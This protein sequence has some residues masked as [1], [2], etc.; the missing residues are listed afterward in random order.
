MW[1]YEENESYSN[2]IAGIGKDSV[3]GLVQRQGSSSEEEGLLTIG[4]GDF[5]ALNKDNPATVPEGNYLIWG[6]NAGSISYEMTTTCEAEYPLWARKWMLQASYTDTTKR[7]KTTIKI[8]IPE[9]Y[10]DTN[11]LN[12]L[13]IA[14]RGEGDFTTSSEIEY[15]PQSKYDTLG[16]AYFYDV[17]WDIDGSGKDLFSFSH[18]TIMETTV[19][20][21]CPNNSSGTLSVNMCGGKSPFIYLL[22]DNA[23]QQYKGQG[24]RIHTFTGLS[25]GIYT[26][27]VQDSFQSAISQ[28][29]EIPAFDTVDLVLPS[30]YWLTSESSEIIDARKYNSKSFT[31]YVWEKDGVLFGDSAVAVIT[32]PGEYKLTVRDS[33]GCI[34][35]STMEVEMHTLYKGLSKEEKTGLS[36]YKLYPNPTTGSYRVEVDLPEESPVVVRVFAVKGDL[37]EERKDN[38]KK[39]YSFD[40]YLDIKGNYLIEVSTSFGIEVFKLTVVR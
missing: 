9:E 35:T 5:T 37:L 18:G 22:E 38:G 29:I 16:Y 4:I 11:R 23:G 39:H 40:S 7:F 26:L 34:Y 30:T 2:G 6:H 12:Y 10:R 13:V 31:D 33:N 8:Q 17:E 24:E 27:T 3:L 21:S 32:Y 20:A 19:E 14:R 28:Q 25:S 1:N 36:Y 15:I